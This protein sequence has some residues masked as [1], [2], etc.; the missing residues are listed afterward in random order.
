MMQRDS[1]FSKRH[2]LPVTDAE[3]TNVIK[4][5]R[6]ALWL[7]LATGVATLWVALGVQTPLLVGG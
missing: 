3:L 1:A 2:S 6:V 4:R 5:L 7:T